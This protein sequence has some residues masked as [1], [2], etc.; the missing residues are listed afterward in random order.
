MAS[1]FFQIPISV[2]TRVRA[3]LHVCRLSLL[4]SLNPS[5]WPSLRVLV[6]C[7][8]QCVFGVAVAPLWHTLGRSWGEGAARNRGWCCWDCW[9]Y[10]GGWNRL[11]DI[12]L[13]PPG[14]KGPGGGEGVWTCVHVCACVTAGAG[15]WVRDCGK[16]KILRL[17][18][19]DAMTPR[20]PPFP[21]SI[22]SAWAGL[23]FTALLFLLLPT[24]M[25][26]QVGVH[27]ADVSIIRSK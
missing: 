5:R 27:T 10:G 11:V 1:K 6:Q 8:L 3:G 20:R 23:H 26:T 4:G 16:Y 19:L 18:S 2:K 17:L 25:W 9:G 24:I 13:S 22:A 14:D 21:V 7:S 15:G 12:T